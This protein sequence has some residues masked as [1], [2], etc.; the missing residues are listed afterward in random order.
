MSTYIIIPSAAFVDTDN[1]ASMTVSAS[2]SLPPPAQ[3][4]VY[5]VFNGFS[6]EHH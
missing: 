3:S 2:G 4:Q 1:V 5:T 6:V